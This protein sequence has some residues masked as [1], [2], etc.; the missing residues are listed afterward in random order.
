MGHCSLS[1]LSL[2]YPSL[3]EWTNKEQ[4]V[5]DICELGKQIRSTYRSTENRSFRVFNII[6]SDVWG[7]CPANIMNDYRYFM[8]FIV[9]FSHVYLVVFDK[10]IR[11]KYLSASKTFIR[12]YRLNMVQ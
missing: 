4:L 1:I 2:L 8:T 10:K 11:V 5:C 3:Y 12:R 6:H 9:Y 7:P